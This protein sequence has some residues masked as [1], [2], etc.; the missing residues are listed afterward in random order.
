MN[1]KDNEYFKLYVEIN[2]NKKCKA[3]I[4]VKI[5]VIDQFWGFTRNVIENWTALV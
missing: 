5:I 3:L 4:V 2:H 1:V